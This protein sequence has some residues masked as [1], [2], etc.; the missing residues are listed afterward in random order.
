MPIHCSET[1]VSSPGAI[2]NYSGDDAQRWDEFVLR[3]DQATFCHLS[4]WIRV[5]ENTWD[6]PSRSLC[7]E[8]D[9]A[10]CGVLPLFYIKSRLFGSMLV[11]TPNAVYGGAVVED[12]F[13]YDQL[14]RVAREMA[15]E[16]GVDYMELRESGLARGRS[17]RD[18]DEGFQIQNL[19]VTFEHPIRTDQ[20]ALMR[21]FPRDIRR[22]I[23]QGPK[24]GLTSELGRE[25]LLDEFYDVYATSVRN[26]GTPVFPKRLFAEFLRVFPDRCDILIIRRGRSVAGGVMSFYFRD[27]VLPYYGGAYPDFYRAGINN[28]MYWE[29]MCSAATRGYTRFDFGRSK[30]GS[31]SYE[32][33]RG[34][35]MRERSLPYKFL[36]ICAR[37]MPSLNPTNPKF[38]LMIEAWKRL[39]VSVTK[40]IGPRIVKNLP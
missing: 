33:K 11:S 9:D 7:L 17:S 37:E 15:S 38:K 10:I 14:I 19:Y 35:G 29:L 12:G 20:D 34:W 36:L 26:L 39:P 21:S 6:H 3:A 8:C 23:R 18:L 1:T 31:G 22:M 32:F 28:F 30:I 13:A 27:S 24:H 2:K 25:D 5:I 40:L 16:L 4:G